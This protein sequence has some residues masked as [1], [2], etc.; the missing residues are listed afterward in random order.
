MRRLDTTSARLFVAIAEEGSIA[1]AAAREHI[2]ASAVSK[3]LSQLESMTGVA[4]VERGQHGIRLTP[5]GEAMAHHARM[6]VQ[7]L[8]HMQTEMSEYAQGVRGHIRVRISVSA[9]AAGLPSQIQRFVKQHAGVKIDLEEHETPF[10][11]R[12]VAEGRADI[13]L[14]PDFFGHEGL[15]LIP[16]K[17]YDLA[18]AVPAKHPLARRKDVRYAETLK[19]EQVEQNQASALSQL[20]DY[21]ARQSSAAKKTRIRVRGFDSV[22]NMIGLGLGIGV[23]P[24]FLEAT[25]GRMHNLR[26]IPLT[27]AWAHPMI[28]I[29][30]RDLDSLPSAARAL[31]EH[32]GR[33]ASAP[34]AQT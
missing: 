32:L 30:I 33:L 18:V 25:Y 15:R 28:C 31:V 3:R 6:V 23:V 13:G 20:L 34:D 24:S 14:G 10:I 11:V 7:A 26:F 5:A 22:C 16:Y 29:M 4:L 27:D 19:Y 1:K 8:D 17:R 12:D 9:L 2:V 21:A